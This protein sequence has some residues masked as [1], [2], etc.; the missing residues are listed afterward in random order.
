MKTALYILIW[1][2]LSYFS[3][4]FLLGILLQL[5][6]L[7]FQCKTKKIKIKRAKLQEVLNGVK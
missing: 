4:W 5:I 7:F 3:L 1:L 6:G 2:G